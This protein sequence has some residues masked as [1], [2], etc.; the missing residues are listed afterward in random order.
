MSHS[1]A[2]LE[3]SAWFYPLYVSLCCPIWSI[4]SIFSVFKTPLSPRP[5]RNRST[6]ISWASG[7]QST[8]SSPSAPRA[9]QFKRVLQVNVLGKL[10]TAKL[11]Q[12]TLTSHW[13]ARSS[14][15][16]CKVRFVSYSAY[17][18]ALLY[19]QILPYHSSP[20]TINI[21]WPQICGIISLQIF[22]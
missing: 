8:A 12:S 16:S 7:T 10:H 9:R 1:V 15:K 18:W 4:I 22:V 17:R 21:V 11:G 14:Q 2:W 20:R 13:R 6:G 19:L 5:M 3:V